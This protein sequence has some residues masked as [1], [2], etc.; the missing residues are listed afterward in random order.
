MTD[1]ELERLVRAANDAPDD[2]MRQVEAAYACDRY[3]DEADA[4]RYYDAAWALGVPDGARRA[5]L[6]G[7]GSTL[8]NVGR[9]DE[10]IAVL[11]SAIE[12]FP[13]FAPL[14]AFLA[15]SLYSAGR[16]REAMAASLSAVLEAA[17][18][19]GSLDRYDRA[20][21][22]YRDDLTGE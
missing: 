7:Y 15:L 18:D 22:Y 9:C 11:R 14:P 12:E 8:R 3:G 17:G 10:S 20:L 6:V 1:A 13:G 2:V 5:F 16:Y 21:R 19:S 4:I